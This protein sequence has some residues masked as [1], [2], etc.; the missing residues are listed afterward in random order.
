[1]IERIFQ[2]SF[3][4][5]YFKNSSALLLNYFRCWKQQPTFT[6]LGDLWLCTFVSQCPCGQQEY[7]WKP[8]PPPMAGNNF[9]TQGCDCDPHNYVSR[10]SQRCLN[11]FF[12]IQH[13]GKCDTGK[14]QL[15]RNSD[16]NRL[17]LKS[18]TFANLKKQKN[19]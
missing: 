18:N 3:Y 9:T 8:L 16:L 1:M 12:T 19:M 2:S 14:I 6:S 7:S 13:K 10:G 11:C 4:S 15:E 5:V 17:R